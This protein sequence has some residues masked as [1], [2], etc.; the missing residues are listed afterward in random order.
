MTTLTFPHIN[1]M[2]RA[3]ILAFLNREKI[4]F[5]ISEPDDT[6]MTKEQLYSKI[7]KGI[8][9]YKQG[10]TKKLDVEDINSFLGL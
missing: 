8:E 4:G 5:N 2:Q 9:E 1:Y 3:A 6:F 10:K 7:D